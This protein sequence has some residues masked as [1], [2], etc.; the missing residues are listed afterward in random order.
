VEGAAIGCKNYR[1]P[2]N[3]KKDFCGRASVI[4]SAVWKY[5]VLSTDTSE[6]IGM[7]KIPFTGRWIWSS[8]K[9]NSATARTEAR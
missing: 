5:P 7:L 1:N 2:G 6:I 3:S 8:A 9:T 4:T